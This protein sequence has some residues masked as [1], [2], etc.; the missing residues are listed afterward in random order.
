SRSRKSFSCKDICTT[1]L[2]LD[3][4]WIRV[5]LNYFLQR[6]TCRHKILLHFFSFKEKE[7]YGHLFAPPL[8]KVFDLCSDMECEQ[9]HSVRKQHA[10]ELPQSLHD[11]RARDVH[12][13]IESRDPAVRVVLYISKRQHVTPLKEDLWIQTPCLFHHRR[14][15][16]DAAHFCS[17]TV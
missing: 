9:Q 7:I 15:Q 11:L 10:L 6:K 12:D 5:S 16:I 13:R 17:P 2:I 14:G 1:T 4:F 8:V 3:R